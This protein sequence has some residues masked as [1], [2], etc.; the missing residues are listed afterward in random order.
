LYDP[1]PCRETAVTL[2]VFSLLGMI[3]YTFTF[4]T[5]EIVVVYITAALLGSVKTNF[6]LL[7]GS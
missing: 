2:F 6:P 3:A 1:V 7:L 5:G 4:D